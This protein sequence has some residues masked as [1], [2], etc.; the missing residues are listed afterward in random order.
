MLCNSE[1]GHVVAKQFCS[2][3]FIYCPQRW[4]YN[5]MRNRKNINVLNTYKCVIFYTYIVLN[6]PVALLPIPLL[7]NV[8][9]PKITR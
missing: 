9:Q 8:I 7:S 6:F 5:I 2:Q 4:K 1:T 3:T